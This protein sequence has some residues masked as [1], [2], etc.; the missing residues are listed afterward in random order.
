MKTWILA[1]Q[2]MMLFSAVLPAR[3]IQRQDRWN[4]VWITNPGISETDYNVVLFRKTFQLESAPDK[5]IINITAD[6]HYRLYVNGT[7]VTFGPQESDIRHWRYETVDLAP[8]LQKGD[9]LVAAEVV[10]WGPDRA[11]GI[12]SKRTAFLIQGESPVEEIINTNTHGWKTSVNHAFTP[13]PVNWMYG[14]DIKGGFYA[15][16]SGDT[17][18]A[19]LYPWGWNEAGYDDSTWQTAEWSYS[20]VTSGGSFRWILE[21]RNTPLQAHSHERFTNVLRHDGLQIPEG[22]LRGKAPVIIPANTHKTLLIDQTYLT[23]G[24]PELIFSGGKD[25]SITISYAENLYN[26]E[27]MKGNRNETEGKTMI[28]I[29]DVVLPDGGE[30]HL[31]KT[32]SR[33]AFRF[34]QLDITTAGSP[35]TIVDYY[36]DYTTTPIEKKA[37]FHS[38]KP[39]YDSITDICWRTL[40]LCTQDNFMSDAYYETMQYVGDSRPHAFSWISM[41]GDKQHMKNAIGQ[42][43]YSRLPDG[44]LTSCY[45]LKATFVH[46]TYSLV[47]IDMIY[48]Y[49][50]Y[51]GDKAFIRPFLPDI[52]AVFDWFERHLNENGIPGK[53]EWPYFVDWYKETGNGTSPVSKNGNSAVITLQWIYSLQHAAD[54][55]NWFGWKAQADRFR[56]RSADLQQKVNALFYDSDKGIYAEDPQKTFYDERP[57]IMAVLTNTVPASQQEAL[58]GRVLQQKNISRAG[59]YYRYNFFDALAHAHAGEYFDQVL[60]PW[61]DVVH[62]GLTTTPE[63]PI[64][65]QPRSECHPWST[66]PVYAWFHVLCGIQPASPA[67]A[68]ATIAPNPGNLEFIK[69]EYPHPSGIINIDLRFKKEK[70]KGEITIPEGLDAE[71]IWKGEK[72]KLSSGTNNI[73][74]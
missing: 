50:M 4:A 5:F 9:N 58:I 62:A 14:V 24:Y 34:I 1:L 8:F 41:T 20:S 42:F 3:D 2:F 57:N 52:S 19:A 73:S 15:A 53:S 26:N 31:Y 47:W 54:I 74:L 71:F 40:K 43:H 56:E 21:P 63:K 22:F 29:K 66:S 51:F 45:P 68:K 23:I 70:V 55:Y 27:K 36:N 12:I 64:D 35:L 7:Y 65:Q 6:N 33:K 38:N 48:D 59:L 37:G 28:G 39:I 49:M 32:L 10:N 46:P 30:M 11:F 60:Q 25:A 67:F 61:V 72:L 17:L 16:N 18:N 13:K 44:N 69:A